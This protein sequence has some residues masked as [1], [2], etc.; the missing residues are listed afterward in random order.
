MNKK[1]KKSEAAVPEFGRNKRTITIR[2]KKMNTSYGSRTFNFNKILKFT[3]SNLEINES[4]AKTKI[5]KH[6]SQVISNFV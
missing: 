6:S 2:P 3:E 5:V 1:I 4:Y